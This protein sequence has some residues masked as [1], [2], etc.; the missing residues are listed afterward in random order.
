MVVLLLFHKGGG[1]EAVLD[2]EEEDYSKRVSRLII[3]LSLHLMNVPLVATVTTTT[4]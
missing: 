3:D 1:G 4:V 2:F